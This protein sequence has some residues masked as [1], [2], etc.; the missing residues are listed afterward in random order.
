MLQP[1]HP[2]RP[3]CLGTAQVDCSVLQSVRMTTL[4]HGLTGHKGTPGMTVCTARV[5]A[6]IA[7]RPACA[8]TL[9]VHLEPLF[10]LQGSGDLLLT[11][12]FT[13]QELHFVLVP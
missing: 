10:A 12:A 9:L 1:R 13:D 7:S 4:T 3:R 2:L 11:V 6:P 8:L 5:P